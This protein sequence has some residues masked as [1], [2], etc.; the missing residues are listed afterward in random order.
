MTFAYDHRRRLFSKFY[1]WAL[2]FMFLSFVCIVIVP[3]S[4]LINEGWL[5]L[6][7]C[8]G[9]LFFGI[10]GVLIAMAVMSLPSKSAN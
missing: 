10:A 7:Y 1:T 9:A 8:F 4:A 6:I 3:M 5:Q 2:L